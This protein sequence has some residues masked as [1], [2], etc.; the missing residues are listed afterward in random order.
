[1]KKIKRVCTRFLAGG[2]PLPRAFSVSLTSEDRRYRWTRSTGTSSKLLSRGGKDGKWVEGQYNMAYQPLNENSHLNKWTVLEKNEN[3]NFPEMA[4]WNWYFVTAH[5]EEERISRR[6]KVL[7]ISRLLN[8]WIFDFRRIQTKRRKQ[9]FCKRP[10]FSTKQS[11]SWQWDRVKY[12]L[13][14]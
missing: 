8:L 2:N 14:A 12:Q 6:V 11:L 13:H 1:M 4:S 3:L 7:Q 5:V 10:L 9:T